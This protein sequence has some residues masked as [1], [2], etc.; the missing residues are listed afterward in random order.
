MEQVDEIPCWC[1]LTDEEVRQLT[2]ASCEIYTMKWVDTNKNAYLR[3][4]N[5]Y[6]SAP[7]KYRSR[8]FGCENW[9][10]TEG[11]RTDSPAGDVD[12]HNI[13]RSWCAQAC[14]LS[15]SCDFTNGYF[16]GQE[17]DR[18]LLFRIPAEGIP[19]EEVAGGEILASRV[20]VYGTKDTGRG[21]WLRLKNKCKQ[22]NF[23][24]NQI[25]PTLFTLRDDESRILAVMSSNV[26]DLLYGYLPE[27]ADAMNSVL[28][29]FLVGK[30]KHGAFR[31]CR[32][33]ISTRRRLWPSCHSQRQH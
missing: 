5:D 20:P 22:F 23:S 8:L 21:W 7:A 17:I 30:E 15:H 14:V 4:D 28:R 12:S 25:V 13:V 10:T 1:F 31:F 9:E 6:V 26:D 29:K 2:E 32:K 16:Q 3:R 24:L 18:I 19:E 27:G 33:R 11:L